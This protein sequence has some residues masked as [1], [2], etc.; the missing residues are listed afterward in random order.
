MAS[1]WDQLRKQARQL[2]TDIDAKLMA[3]SR[4]VAST[5]ATAQSATAV[6]S[7][8]AIDTAESEAEA[9]LQQVGPDCFAA[10][11]DAMLQLSRVIDGLSECLERSYPTGAGGIRNPSLMHLLQRHRDVLY[12]YTKEFKKL[13]VNIIAN[14]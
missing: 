8:R 6:S 14:G 13:K 7:H 3:F 5:S 4:L 10:R 2:E 9:A 1:E 11:T 12:D